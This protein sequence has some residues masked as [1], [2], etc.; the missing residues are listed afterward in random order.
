VLGV[1]LDEETTSADA[2][3]GAVE[4]IAK[5]S[6][7][8]GDVQVVKLESIGGTENKVAVGETGGS[9]EGALREEGCDFTAGSSEQSA[10]ASR[11]LQNLSA[12]GN[13]KQ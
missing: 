5:I 8:R 2:Q 4:R 6:V 9:A 12:G 1:A 13:A 7:T 11:K 10:A 3:A